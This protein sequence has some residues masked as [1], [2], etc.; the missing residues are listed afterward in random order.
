MSSC[1]LLHSKEQANACKVSLRTK[2][3]YSMYIKRRK[4]FL[5]VRSEKKFAKFKK[6]NAGKEILVSSSIFSL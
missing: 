3:F 2:Y 5:I 6:L 4:A 1:I